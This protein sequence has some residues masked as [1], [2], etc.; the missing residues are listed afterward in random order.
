MENQCSVCEKKECNLTLGCQVWCKQGQEPERLTFESS[1]LLAR[2]VGCQHSNSNFRPHP[3]RVPYCL[4]SRTTGVQRTL[5]ELVAA[6]IRHQ[7][8]D[9]KIYGSCFIVEAQIVPTLISSII[10]LCW[11]R[12]TCPYP[13]RLFCKPP[14][15]HSTPTMTWN[16]CPCLVCPWFAIT[17]K[18]RHN[19][20][21]SQTLSSH[22]G[23]ASRPVNSLYIPSLWSW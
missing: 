1:R 19:S 6:L 10:P 5:N 23:H 14:P 17:K 8:P 12:P 11:H 9:R 2:A 21:V 22:P 18:R 7:Y 13:P 4:E 3:S 16:A 15:P 20:A